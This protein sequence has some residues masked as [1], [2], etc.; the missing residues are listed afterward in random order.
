[1]RMIA[2]EAGISVGALYLY[3]RNKEEL[4]FTVFK[5]LFKD[6]VSQI[7]ER[8]RDLSDPTD[9]IRA[10]IETYMEMAK[11]HREFIYAFNKEKGFTFGVEWKRKF[12]V[13]L[14]ALVDGI[15]RKGVER[16]VFTE[17]G[18]GEAT[19]VVISALRGYVLSIVIDPD[20]LFSPGACA[21]ILLNGLVRRRGSGE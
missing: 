12:F 18:E 14:R 21:D 6:F 15:V 5:D 1:M 16:G 4:C 2:A 9:Q 3:Y 11:S 17:V 10:Y 13:E 7:E 8:V 20:N 19:K